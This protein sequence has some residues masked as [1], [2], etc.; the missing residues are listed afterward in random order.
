MYISLKAVCVQYP[1]D[2]KP[3]D[4]SHWCGV[5][6]LQVWFWGSSCGHSGLFATDASQGSTVLHQ[7]Q[8]WTLRDPAAL[9]TCAPVRDIVTFRG[10]T[11]KKQN[12]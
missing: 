4:L 10:S 12:P 5:L 1:I 8:S 2:Q 9:D 11:G 7:M 6:Y 3:Y